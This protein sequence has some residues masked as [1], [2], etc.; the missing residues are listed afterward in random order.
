MVI[1]HANIATDN[2]ALAYMDNRAK[3]KY[4]VKIKYTQYSKIWNIKSQ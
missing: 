3:I 1:Y 2:N 4:D